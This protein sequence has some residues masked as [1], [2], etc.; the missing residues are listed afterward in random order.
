MKRTNDEWLNDLRAGGDKQ[1]LA[2][3]DLRALIMRGLPYA[4]SGKISVE[5]PEFEALAEEVTQESLMRV[6]DNLHTFEGRSQFTTWVQKIAVRA[7]LTEL[8]RVRWRNVPLPDMM[9]GDDPDMPSYEVADNQPNPEVLLERNELIQLVNRIIMEELSEKQ[10]KV[11]MMV[12]MQG[13]PLEEAAQHIGS[14]RNALYK[15]MHDARL[16]LKHRLEENGLTPSQ[17]LAV[18]EKI[19]G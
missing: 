11:L 15:L 7:A 18:F 19:T 3:E 4:L 2:L 16:Q 17:I 6:L 5:S 9:V 10:R 14:N 13:M 8:R 1:A 12:A